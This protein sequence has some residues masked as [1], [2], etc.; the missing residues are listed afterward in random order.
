MFKCPAG[1]SFCVNKDAKGYF[2]GVKV[3]DTPVCMLTD[4]ALSNCDA[5]CSKKYDVPVRISCTYE[6]CPA[7][8]QK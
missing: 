6:G 8:K 5:M 1:K 4:Y 2:I 7:T 3:E